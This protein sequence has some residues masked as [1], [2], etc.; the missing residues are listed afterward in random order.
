M[1]KA[2]EVTLKQDIENVDWQALADVYRETL[3]REDPA[4]LART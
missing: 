4:Q 2:T 3:G 1:R